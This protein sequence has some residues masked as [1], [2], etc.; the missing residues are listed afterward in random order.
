MG[1]NSTL[2]LF[3]PMRTRCWVRV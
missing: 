2:Q 1:R 3:L